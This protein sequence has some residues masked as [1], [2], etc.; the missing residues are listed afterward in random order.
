MKFSN[1]LS[2]LLIISALFVSCKND[3]LSNGTGKLALSVTDAP[4]D[5]ANVKAVYVTFTGL[6]Y[7]N[8]GGSWETATDFTS[9]QVVNI[10]DLQNGKTSLLGNYTLK[11]GNYTGLRFKLDAPTKGTNNPSNPGC[12]V[13]LLTGEKMPLFVPSGASSGY[14]ANGNFSVPINGVVEVTA[15]FDLRKSIVVTGNG[16]TYILNP[17]IKIV[18]NNQS[19]TISG[20]VSNLVTDK[21]YVIYTYEK[22]KYTASESAEPTGENVRFA[23]AISSTKISSTGAYTLA[24]LAAG[25]YDLVVVSENANGAV[26]VEKQISAIVVQS[27][28]TT[29]LNIAL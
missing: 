18:V 16:S 6:E 15:D 23:N 20:L 17:T 4:I 28:K 8:S 22:D 3:D 7:Q 2:A 9:P 24:F 29:S 10:L 25:S 26:A 11:S 21:K 5:A 12:Y 13:E 14:K 1:Q 19:G 27:Q